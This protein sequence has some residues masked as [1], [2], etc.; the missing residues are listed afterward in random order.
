MN[1]MDKDNHDRGSFPKGTGGII[2]NVT[3]KVE[4]GIADA[5]LQWML[6]EHIPEVMKTKCFDGYKV[7]R[8]LDV[9]D[10]E[11]P[12]FAIQYSA[13]SKA[14]YN[15]YIELFASQMSKRSFEK[16]SDRFISFGSV[17]E[18]VK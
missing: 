2:Y 11:G 15:R 14:D 9:D 12:T 1:E 6:D 17:M 7:V 4:P 16:W 3:T 10:S 18:V 13:E 8:L 5:W